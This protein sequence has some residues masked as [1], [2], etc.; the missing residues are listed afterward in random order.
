MN[1]IKKLIEIVEKI[2]KHGADIIE[3]GFA[4][5][6]FYLAYF[7]DYIP[8]F[9][10]LSSFNLDDNNLG[11]YSIF[12]LTLSSA[13]LLSTSILRLIYS[14]WWKIFLLIGTGCGIRG[15]IY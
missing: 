15:K 5:A 11:Y 3:I 14:Y 2:K 8:G 1:F 9:D 10:S 4:V 6:L 12:I 7:P 13:T